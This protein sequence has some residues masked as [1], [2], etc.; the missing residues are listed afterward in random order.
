ML[1]YSGEFTNDNAVERGME[2]VVAFM[3]NITLPDDQAPA[4]IDA[5]VCTVAR[6]FLQWAYDRNL[7][8]ANQAEYEGTGQFVQIHLT[9]LQATTVQ[10]MVA[11]C[12]GKEVVVNK[13]LIDMMADATTYEL[14]NGGLLMRAV[15]R[16][17]M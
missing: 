3:R 17:E 9:V 13:R 2:L 12:G 7:R 16:W 14:F 1:T 8:A 5:R 6:Q 15:F 10:I 11:D 4:F